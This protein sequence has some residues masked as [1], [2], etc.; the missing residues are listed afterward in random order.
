MTDM[1]TARLQD[2][3]I[4]APFVQNAKIIPYIM[5]S[6]PTRLARVALDSA[7]IWPLAS[8]SFAAPGT[9]RASGCMEAGAVS[10]RLTFVTTVL[11]AGVD[12]RDVQIAAR[13]ADPRTTMRQRA[14]MNPAATRTAFPAAYMASDQPGSHRAAPP[15]GILAN[16]ASGAAGSKPVRGDVLR[17][18]EGRDVRPCI[19]SQR[20]PMM[21]GLWVAQAVDGCGVVSRSWTA[22]RPGAGGER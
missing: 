9:F 8:T 20:S 11:D 1:L 3:E 5:I 12:L 10:G 13:Q 14:R 15:P 19:S 7:L 16:R 4:S 2:A 17:P 18:C 6:Q 21:G 22:I